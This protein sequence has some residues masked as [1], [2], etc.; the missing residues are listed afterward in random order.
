MHETILVAPRY[1]LQTLIGHKAYLI[2]IPLVSLFLNV[3]VQICLHEFKDE[4][5]VVFLANYFFQF[6]NVR[7]RQ[8]PQRLDFSE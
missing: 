7:M 2:F 5:Q 6:D 4:E 1:T 3:L 8:L